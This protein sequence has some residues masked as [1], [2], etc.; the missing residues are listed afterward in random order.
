MT[1]IIERLKSWV[2]TPKQHQMQVEA[3]EEIA[4]LRAQ[5]TILQARLRYEE[6]L[7]E[8]LTSEADECRK[9]ADGLRA[10]LYDAIR[11]KNQLAFAAFG[12]SSLPANR[13]AAE[14]TEASAPAAAP[15]KRRRRL[16]PKAKRSAR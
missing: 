5:L 1:D 7:R 2:Y 6:A 16:A 14:S 12:P 10:E 9:T 4:D 15:K 3:A 13:A 8:Q 11:S